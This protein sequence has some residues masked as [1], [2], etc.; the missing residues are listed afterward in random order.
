[1]DCPGPRR[2]E[3]VFRGTSHRRHAGHSVAHH[4]AFGK[5]RKLEIRLMCGAARC[6]VVGS[7]C[8]GE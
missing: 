7:L 5:L 2:L 1:M 8:Q 3:S 6:D 4:E